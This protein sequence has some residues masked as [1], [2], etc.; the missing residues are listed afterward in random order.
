M[1]VNYTNIDPRFHPYRDKK[2]TLKVNKSIPKDSTFINTTGQLILNITDKELVY[3]TDVNNSEK[4][5][6]IN[7]LIK[8]TNPICI[9][10]KIEI[11]FEKI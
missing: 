3:Y 5:K 7:N 9:G 11:D 2:T 1:N 10:E 8:K 4:I 6:Y